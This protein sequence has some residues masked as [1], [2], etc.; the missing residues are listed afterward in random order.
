MEDSSFKGSSASQEEG[1]S[2]DGWLVPETERS[3]HTKIRIWCLTGVFWFPFMVS[4]KD[5]R[6]NGRGNG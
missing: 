1:K 5:V 3:N 6:D 2:H 4:S